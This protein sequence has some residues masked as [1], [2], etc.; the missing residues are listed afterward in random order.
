MG[1][2]REAV[3]TERKPAG[4]RM[5]SWRWRWRGD[6]LAAMLKRTVLFEEH[7]RLGARMVE[8]GGWEMPIQYTGILDEH[9]AVRS[10][11]GVFDISHMGEVFC[12]GPAAEEFLNLVL[13]NDLRRLVPGQGQYTLLCQR[14]G[15][16][17]DDLFAYRIASTDFL[18]IINASRAEVDVAWLTAR[19]LEFPRRDEVQLTDA[20]DRLS[21]IAVQGPRVGEFVD[22]VFPGEFVDPGSLAGRPSELKR[23]RLS[24]FSFAGTPVWFARTGYTGE[25]GFEVVAPNAVVGDLWRRFLEVGRPHGLKPCG[26]GARDTLRTEMCFPLYGHELTEQLTPIEAGLDVFVALDKPAFN[27]REVMLGQKQ[28]GV[29]RR[30]IAFRI[31]EKG[32]P[33]VR[34]HYP[35]WASGGDGTPLGETTSGTLSPSLGVGIGLAYVPTG[36]A[37]P[38]Q[39]LLIEIRGRRYPAE[40]VKKPLYRR[41]AG[42]GPG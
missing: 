39:A 7:V 30:L 21:A 4:R 25:D 15:G 1:E 8:F 9:L 3:A 11:A 28:S 32:V 24:L 5:P 20:C 23:N 31:T 41:P 38:G 19:L 27:G 10:A 36:L 2:H 26:L 18:L 14:E 33:P 42:P 34:P 40:I 13:T 12:S 17:I 37:Q 16:V 35:I 22:A 29:R 6:T